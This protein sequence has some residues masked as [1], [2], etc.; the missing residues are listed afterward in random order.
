MNEPGRP[1]LTRYLRWVLWLRRRRFGTAAIVAVG[2]FAALAFFVLGA[3]IRLLIGPVSL[4]P[5]AGALSGA[6]AEALPGV[7][8]QYDQAAIEWSREE[9]RVS[10]VI[11]GTRVCDASGRIVAQAPKAD[12]RL[13]AAP[14]LHGNVVV[15]DI[16]LVGVQLTLV[17]A[18]DGTLRLGVG[19]DRQER[20]LIDRIAEALS[21]SKGPSTLESFAVRRARFALYDEGTK[22]FVVSPW[23]DF[24]LTAAAS[25]RLKARV[26][27]TIELAG[28][29]ARLKGEFV[30][31]PKSKMV[32]GQIALIG[33]DLSSLAAGS[34]TFSSLKQAALK[35]DLAA[36]F[37]LDGANLTTADFTLL[38]RG[39]FALP[40]VKGRIAVAGLIAGGRYDGGHH[41]LTLQVSRIDAD[42]IKGS[43]SGR[44]DLVAAAPNA[45]AHTAVDLKLRNLSLNLPGVF[46]G[47]VDFQVA[48]V[49]ADWRTDTRELD[50]ARLIVEGKPFSLKTAG[51]L[52]FPADRS[53][54][55]EMTGEI[56]AMGVR[57][58]VRYWPLIAAGG[59]RA[60]TD[61]NMPAGRVG[62]MTFAL[63]IPP[64]ALDAPALAA[65]MLEMKFALFGVE[66]KYIDGLTHLTAGHGR[67]RLTGTDFTI[68]IDGAKVGALT[69]SPARF[70]IPDLNI[71]DQVGEIDAH[72]S[73]ALADV[74]ALIDMKPLRYPTRFGFSPASARGNAA[75]DIRIDLPLRKSLH[76]DE[77]QIAVKAHS[78]GFGLALGKELRISD[79]TVD[80]S[81]SNTS[82]W[83][84]GSVGL[85]GSGS[86]LGVDWSEDFASAG[87]VTTKIAVKGALDET[88]RRA[89]GLTS[90]AGLKGAMGVTGTLT[91]RRGALRQGNFVADLT[92]TAM[93]INAIGVDKPAGF[94]MA[95]KVGVG[96]GAQAHL[97]D[98]NL[99]LTAQGTSVAVTAKFDEAGALT[100]LQ[101][102]QVRIGP[103]NDFAVTLSKTAGG[104]DISLRGR[105]LDGSRLARQ[106]EVDADGQSG[107]TGGGTRGGDPL[108]G[109]FRVSIRLDRLALRDAV[110]VSNFSLDVAGAGDRLSALTLAGGMGKNVPISASLIQA[111]GARALSFTAA[112]AGLFFKG[113]YGFSGLKGGKLAVSLSIPGQLTLV[114][115]AGDAD[116]KGKL[117]L[118]DFRVVDQPLLARLFT[119]GSLG[120]LINLM[121]GQG[122]AVDELDMPFSSRNRVIAIKGAHATGPAI[123]ITADGYI[124]RPKNRIAVKGTLVPLYGLNSVLGHIPLLGDVLTS[125][126]GEGIFGMSYA[127]EG[128]ADEPKVSV[129][130]L[131]V[132]APGIFRRA[133]EG[134]LPSAAQAPTNNPPKATGP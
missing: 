96:F 82:L 86:K 45:P 5:F 111:G 78:T 35:T 54:G 34:E 9:G 134:K 122:I 38:A 90:F 93:T 24:R 76:V 65:N 102:P 58:L 128:D 10:L 40:A 42:K 3:G 115:S 62:A 124:D 99:H 8:M 70:H 36:K 88:A 127:V 101:A 108:D 91:G 48:A 22:L 125:K 110:A 89:L 123:G 6:L 67:A 126:K 104:T 107:G 30:F 106:G 52:S 83:A 130:P 17:R 26:D 39:T 60:W 113:L 109:P 97:S 53:A 68:D 69:L 103:R 51:R 71:D 84:V 50:V 20:D 74:L 56:G 46:A 95:A 33:F 49:R 2:V 112:D 81:V 23:A 47:P 28:R 94:A 100:S 14:L 73:G 92:P 105:S 55:I 27:A 21:K 37:V 75:A 4:G 114:R 12:I 132:L 98:I 80:F 116:F 66:A 63:H 7:S 129:N 13:A 1:V 18:A 57:D 44:I 61:A 64:G 119:A 133:F 131:S 31:P 79:G 121:Q 59:G 15:K 25:G 29:P 117:V 32:E 19:G 41:R 72:L 16:T 11:L 85:N 43:I 120:G 77:V 118:T 87:P